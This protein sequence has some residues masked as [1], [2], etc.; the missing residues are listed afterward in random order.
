VLGL[1]GPVHGYDICRS[2]STSTRTPDG[3]CCARSLAVVD[4]PTPGAPLSRIRSGSEAFSPDYPDGKLRLGM[5][6]RRLNAE[7]QAFW[8][9]GTRKSGGSNG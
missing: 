6:A 3:R 1:I 9:C 7:K 4:L 5:M 8:C 2:V